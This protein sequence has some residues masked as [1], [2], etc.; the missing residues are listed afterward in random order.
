MKFLFNLFLFSVFCLTICHAQDSKIKI[1]ILSG[2]NNHDWKTTTPKLKHIYEKSGLFEVE[3]TDN[4]ETLNP[5]ELSSFDVIVSNWNSFPEKD[6]RWSVE[7]EKALVEFIEEG[8]GFVTFHA[9]TTC[10]YEWEEFKN[11]STGA[12]IKETRHRKQS[13][14][15]VR[16]KNSKHPIVKG[17]QDFTMHDEHDKF[18]W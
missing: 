6:V 8:G 5:E 7:L 1:L 4:L 16:I 18:V 15:E 9:S 2:R 17:M 13:Q 11:I 14:T 12:W 3:V 10:F